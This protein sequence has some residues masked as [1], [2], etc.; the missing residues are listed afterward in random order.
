MIG[1]DHQSCPVWG[2]VESDCTVV[3]VDFTV[4]VI[5]SLLPALLSLCTVV[6]TAGGGVFKKKKTSLTVLQI[7]N[8]EHRFQKGSLMIYIAI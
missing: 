8:Y 3:T 2:R 1:T 5:V 7:H 4:V 6:V